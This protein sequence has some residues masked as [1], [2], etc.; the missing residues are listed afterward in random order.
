MIASRFHRQDSGDTR[1]HRAPRGLSFTFEEVLNIFRHRWKYALA[2]ALLVAANVALYLLSKPEMYRSEATLLLE[3]RPDQVLNFEEVVDLSLN[4]QFLRVE[5]NN[6]VEQMRSGAFQKQVLEAMSP[7]LRHAMTAP[8]L[9]AWHPEVSAGEVFATQLGV[10]AIYDTQ[11]F[12][13]SFAHPDPEVAAEVTNLAVNEYLKFQSERSRQG[14]EMAVSFLQ[15]QAL[16]WKAQVEAADQSLQRYRQENNLVSLD[17]SQD[18]VTERMK[19][20][21]DSLTE[22]ELELQN[23]QARVDQVEER[24]AAGE[25]LLAIPEV[26]D[27][28]DIAA[29]RRLLAEA[30]TQRDILSEQYLGRHPQML[31]N[32]VTRE[33]LRLE[34]DQSIADAVSQLEGHRDQVAS[35]RDQMA[36]RLD[37]AEQNA[38]A[39]DEKAIQYKVLQRELE[40]NK[41]IYTQVLNRYNETKLAQQLNHTNL[42]LVD[43]ASPAPKPFAPDPIKVGLA[44]CFAFF[45]FF[46]VTPVGMDFFD[47]RARTRDQVEALLQVELLGAIPRQRQ[48]RKHPVDRAVID[49]SNEELI[50]SFRHVYTNFLL[51]SG[52]RP[53]AATVVTSCSPSEGKSFFTSN[54]AACFASHGTRTLIVDLDLRRP[55]QHQIFG[56]ESEE[57]GLL[58]WFRSG[59]DTGGSLLENENLGIVPLTPQLHILRAG[60]A[61]RHASEIIRSERFK[62]FLRRAKAEFDH[63]VIDTPPAGLFSDALLLANEV[64]YSVLVIRHNWATQRNLKEMSNRLMRTSSTL[65]GTVFNR[66]RGQRREAG[67]YNITSQKEY[68]YYAKRGAG[69]K[70]SREQEV[71]KNVS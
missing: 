70:E 6:N 38:L 45:V 15:E 53:H 54:I 20:L 57:H 10:E 67:Y 52:L 43:A 3:N 35:R 7:Q 28:G 66:V 41:E 16:E 50:E 30:Q 27:F 31:Q 14:L 42:R 37:Q 68:K 32:A 60:G 40:T 33:A 12:S 2:L 55:R 13:M 39:L 23:A 8:F 4:R 19:A 9:E 24:R 46:V 1:S 17:D 65:I 62:S 44:S 61:T 34:L 25:S 18:I 36:L 5:Q 56:S 22:I 47:G 49:H 11:L 64:E 48:S 69:I 51:E 63:V 71:L 59:A 26:A 21:S 58:P 29:V